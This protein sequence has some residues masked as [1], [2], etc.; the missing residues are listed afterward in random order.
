MV[1]FKILKLFVVFRWIG[2]RYS[3]SSVIRGLIKLVVGGW[4]R[5]LSVF[6]IV[7]ILKLYVIGL[8][9]RLVYLRVI[10]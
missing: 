6:V 5:L 4:V 9:M 1:G 2:E 3:C 8:V 10:L 7:Y